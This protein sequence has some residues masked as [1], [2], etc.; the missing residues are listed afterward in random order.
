M[1][2]QAQYEDLIGLTVETLF[3]AVTFRPPSLRSLKLYFTV[4]QDED[5]IDNWDF[6]PS[7]WDDILSRLSNISSLEIGPYSL[8]CPSILTV[9]PGER[10]DSPFPPLWSLTIVDADWDTIFLALIREILSSP[11]SEKLNMSGSGAIMENVVRSILPSDK[12]LTEWR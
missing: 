8:P 4:V 1:L 9:F 11:I 3:P 2:C 5:D 12:T 7:P 6:T 10:R